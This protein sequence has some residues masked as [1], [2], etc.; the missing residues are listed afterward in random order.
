MTRYLNSGGNLIDV[1]WFFSG[2]LVEKLKENKTSFFGTVR[3]NSRS[4]PAVA[5]STAARIKK[6]TRV[7][8]NDQGT[9][10][11]S[12]WE[13]KNKPVLLLDSFDR[14]VPIPQAP[15][16]PLSV[17]FYKSTKSGVDIAD[18]KVRGLSCKRKC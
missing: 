13:K 11:V 18:K 9:A 10:L 1:N 2:E 16:K 12:F 4:V 15:E 5:K 6:D 8:Y 17:N 3:Q 7:F 14:V